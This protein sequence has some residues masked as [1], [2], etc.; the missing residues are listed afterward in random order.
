MLVTSA[1]TSVVTASDDVRV[2][3][4]TARIERVS[5][6]IERTRYIYVCLMRSN[7]YSSNS[8]ATKRSQFSSSFARIFDVSKYV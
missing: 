2:W 3:R 6:F 5:L 7:N 4:I 1:R 8:C